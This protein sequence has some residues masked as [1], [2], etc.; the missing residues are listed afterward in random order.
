[1]TKKRPQP[2]LSVTMNFDPSRRQYVFN[3]R[4]WTEEDVLALQQEV[5]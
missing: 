3:V 5:K 2:D 1:M 4:A